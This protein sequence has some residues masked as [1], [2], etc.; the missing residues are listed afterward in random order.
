MLV[1]IYKLMLSAEITLYFVNY[2][3]IDCLRNL[4]G[5][6]MRIVQ[7]SDEGIPS[8]DHFMMEIINAKKTSLHWLENAKQVESEF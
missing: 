4:C 1:V 8:G 5:L 3:L 6:S 2:M 7:G